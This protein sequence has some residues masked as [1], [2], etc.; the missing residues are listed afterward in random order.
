[1][2]LVI[3]YYV[4]YRF[5]YWLYVDVFWDNL[6]TLSSLVCSAYH[7]H[8]SL[9]KRVVCLVFV[10]QS[11]EFVYCDLVVDDLLNQS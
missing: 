10:A 5:R 1:M 4:A 2:F 6:L 11:V 3:V 7:F 9:R 8:A